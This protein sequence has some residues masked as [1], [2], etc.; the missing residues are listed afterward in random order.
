MGEAPYSGK[1]ALYASGADTPVVE[2]RL[3]EGM[4]LGFRETQQG[5]VAVAGIHEQTLT[6]TPG[7]GKT[8]YYWKL[9]R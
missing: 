9:E 2:Y 4:H 8:T 7:A 1:Y 3:E 6:F 5:V